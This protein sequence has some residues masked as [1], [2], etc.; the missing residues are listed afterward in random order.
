MRVCEVQPDQ[1]AFGTRVYATKSARKALNRCGARREFAS[2]IKELKNNGNDDILLLS[3][4]T[5]TDEYE[6]ECFI[7]ADLLKVSNTL[8]KSYLTNPFFESEK[9]IEKQPGGKKR[10]VDLRW[11]YSVIKE[12]LIPIWLDD[13]SFKNVLSKYKEL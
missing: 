12:D 11:I 4:R 9:L 6:K 1:Q 8:I 2:Q 13:A 10:Y 5:R 3:A 7:N